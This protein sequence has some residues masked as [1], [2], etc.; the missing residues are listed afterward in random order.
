MR[1]MITARFVTMDRS[2]PGGVS[3]KYSIAWRMGRRVFGV[4][5]VGGT[6]KRW[7]LDWPATVYILKMDFEEVHFVLTFS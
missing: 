4:V 1:G 5:W 7:W 6:H 2:T 3:Y